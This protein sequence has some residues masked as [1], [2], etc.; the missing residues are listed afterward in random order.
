MLAG[1]VSLF[2]FP[3]FK[4]FQNKIAPSGNPTRQPTRLKTI[5]SVP[6]QPRGS[7]ELLRFD[8]LVQRLEAEAL[9]LHLPVLE[10]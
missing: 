1:C 5:T 8:E 4:T 10:A 7:S 3:E 9:E 2:S 6:E